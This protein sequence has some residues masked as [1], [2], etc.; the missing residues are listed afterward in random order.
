MEEPGRLQSIESQ[1]VGHNC[2]FS[3]FPSGPVVETLHLHPARGRFSPWSGNYDPTC[4]RAWTKTSKN[5]FL[6]RGL[7]SLTMAPNTIC[8]S[9]SSLSSEVPSSDDITMRVML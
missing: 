8:S 7:G 6:N 4:H 9:L 2:D 1:R 5:F 3:L